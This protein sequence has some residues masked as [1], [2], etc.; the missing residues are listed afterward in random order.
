[1]RVVIGYG[2]VRLCRT[3]LGTPKGDVVSMFKLAM[4]LPRTTG[5]E[6]WTAT[7]VPRVPGRQLAYYRCLVHDVGL[8]VSNHP[9]TLKGELSLQVEEGR[10][11]G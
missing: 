10:S 5:G 2:K 3:S 4:G 7:A 6:I 9:F 8:T 11:C 1:M